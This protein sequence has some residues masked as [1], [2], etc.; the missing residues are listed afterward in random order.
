MRDCYDYNIRINAR[1][2]CYDGNLVH[3]GV[4]KIIGET[5]VFV[6]CDNKLIA[7]QPTNVEVYGMAWTEQNEREY[8]ATRR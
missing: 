8:L 7:F 1:V 3:D 2:R 5:M 4:V 6:E